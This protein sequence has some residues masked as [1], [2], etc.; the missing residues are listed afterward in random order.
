MRP[1]IDHPQQVK[2]LLNTTIKSLEKTITRI[3][4]TDGHA[5]RVVVRKEE[6]VEYKARAIKV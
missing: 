2:L 3:M 1:R 6:E 4:E 5:T